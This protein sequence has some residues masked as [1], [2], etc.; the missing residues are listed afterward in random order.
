MYV[1]M[2]V[3]MYYVCMYVCMYVLR[4]YVLR[5]Y[6]LRMYVCIMY[7]LRMYVCIR[8]E[9]ENTEKKDRPYTNIVTV[10]RVHV[11]IFAVEKQLSVTCVC[12]RAILVFIRHAKPVHRLILTSVSCLAVPYFSTLC[13]KR[14]DF[15]LG[16]GKLNIKFVF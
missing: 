9:H 5:M 13:Q 1:C 7:V 12:I 15:F 3:C 6:V 11:I 2:Y 10:K 16:G 8:K 14:H 4:M